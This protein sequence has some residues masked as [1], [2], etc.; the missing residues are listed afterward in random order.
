M[1]IW[2]STAYPGC[3]PARKCRTNTGSYSSLSRHD[4][5]FRMSN[6]ARR[7][8]V[9]VEILLRFIRLYKGTICQRKVGPKS[10]RFS[11]HCPHLRSVLQMLFQAFVELKFVHQRATSCRRIKTEHSDI[12]LD[13]E[14][15]E[16]R[17]GLIREIYWSTL[18]MYHS[19]FFKSSCR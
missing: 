7:S 3:L 10:V 1:T 14:W 2:V 18:S 4:I 19:V 13:S 5:S 17:K 16:Y 12:F 15:P 9:R 8:H 11:V 6:T